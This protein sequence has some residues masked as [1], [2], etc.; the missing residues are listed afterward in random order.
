VSAGEQKPA[1]LVSGDVLPPQLSREEARDLTDRARRQAAA[2][3]RTLLRLYEGGG[4]LALGYSSWG[5][6]FAAEF[7]GS[8]GQGYRLL[9]AARVEAEVSVHVDTR[10]MTEAH[11]RVLAPLPLDRRRELID[12]IRR[13]GGF[14][15]VPAA[16]LAE[17][18]R[19]FR[20]A[21]GREER[22]ALA[23]NLL[24]N[25][26]DP[27]PALR[28]AQLGDVEDDL[29]RLA[30]AEPEQRERWRRLMV[31]AA[32]ITRYAEERLT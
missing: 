5:A 11:A 14:D 1:P 24:G 31:N 4:H 19:V 7:G 3:W 32:A 18:A 20:A 16:R 10:E 29:L 28:A 9:R 2:L 6:Y 23:M 8:R 26:D 17:I 30:E 21:R 22:A 13:A 15:R 25:P 12:L 27:V